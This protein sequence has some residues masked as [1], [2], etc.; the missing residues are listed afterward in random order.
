MKQDRYQ[1]EM[2]RFYLFDPE[3]EIDLSGELQEAK[4]VFNEKGTI[5]QETYY[6]NGVLHGP[7]T[8]F[9]KEGTMVALT[10]FYL[11]Q[12]E[13]KSFRYY[14]S[15]KLYGLERYKENRQVGKQEYYYENG[16]LK[17]LLHYNKEGLLHG[18]VKL[19]WPSGTPKRFCRFMNGKKEGSEEIWDEQG[20]YHGS[21]SAA[22]S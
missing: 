17:T 3:L 6:L 10:W 19:F 14:L 8:F 15:G 16:T 21:S 13:G 18:E 5:A 1:I 4:R 12:R 22:L 2:N 11:G 9:S 7:S 20:K